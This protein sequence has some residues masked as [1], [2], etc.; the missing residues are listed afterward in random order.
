MSSFH[1]EG[2]SLGCLKSSRLCNLPLRELQG[3]FCVPDYYPEINLSCDGFNTST[4]SSRFVDT[5]GNVLVPV[6]EGV[7]KRIIRTFFE[8]GFKDALNEARNNEAVASNPIISSVA[9]FAFRAMKF[10]QDWRNK[11]L[12][13][14]E[15]QSIASVATYSE[16][17]GWIRASVRY[18]AWHPNCFKIAVAGVDDLVRIYTDQPA[19]VPV[20]KGTTQKWIA[21]MA[22][23]PFTAAELA[24]GCQKGI[25]L[26]VID[27]NINN[28]YPI[29]SVQ[30]STDG[31]L[32]ASA[33]IGN[34]DIIL[35]HI[36]KM[37]SI[38][39]KRVGPRCSLL[40][41][42]PDG[43][44]LFSATVG[45]VCR[46][47]YTERK[48]QPERWAISKGHIQSACWSPCADFLLFITSE[49]SIL[50]RLQFVEEQLFK[51]SENKQIIKQ[52]KLQEEYSKSFL[53]F[54][55][56]CEQKEAS[57]LVDL[58]KIVVGERELGGKPQALAWDPK[59]LFLAITFQDTDCIAIFSTTI[60]KYDLTVSPSSF[61]TGVGKEYPTYICFQS[62]NRKS[63]NTVLTVGWSSGRIQ[64][65]P[66]MNS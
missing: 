10:M 34:T 44:C 59:G 12:P 11:I 25:C 32:L 30:W 53:F 27:N 51:C 31:N 48:W 8:S 13:H 33:S 57:P 42:S 62:E 56:E 55:A 9:E 46:V 19:V 1:K 24:V 37:E 52:G 5:W 49:E 38:A 43:S 63:P 16:T 23:R 36:D 3:N 17:R 14:M 64:F 50:Y 22:W 28:H 61:L 21:C 20:L 15:E 65:V 4:Q 7:L 41:W 26:W 58:R 40:K 54:T 47:W 66:L 45:N 35:W 29:T 60:Q 18:I 2:V 6:N 39:L